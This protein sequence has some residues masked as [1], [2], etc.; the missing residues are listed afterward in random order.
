MAGTEANEGGGGLVITGMYVHP[1]QSVKSGEVIAEVSDRP[2]YLLQGPLPLWRDL[3]PGESGK[4]VMELQAALAHLNFSSG[5]DSYGYFGPG[6]EEAVAAFYQ[7]IGYPMPV[8]SIGASNVSPTAPSQLPGNSSG[9]SKDVASKPA[10][11]AIVPMSEAWFVPD[12]PAIAL[13]VGAQEGDHSPSSL[14]TLAEGGLQL[15]GQLDPSEASLIRTGMNVV[16]YSQV[17]G[18]SGIGRVASMGAEVAASANNGGAAYVPIGIRAAKPWPASLNGQNV[19]ITI[20]AVTTG[21]AVLAVPVAAVSSDA[22]G[23]SEV[24]IEDRD[25]IEHRIHVRTGMSA[26]GYVAIQSASPMLVAGT[27]AVVGQ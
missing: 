16:V 21:K 7:S 15:K 10:I 27:Q 6:T 26:D 5:Y 24:V 23:Q 2:V 20:T 14:I 12:L 18:F 13:S 3:V 17:T 22:S 19:E 8:E 9:H 25:G 1:G 11:E 4:D